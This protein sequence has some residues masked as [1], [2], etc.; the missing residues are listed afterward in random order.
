[1]ADNLKTVSINS[2]YNGF[3]E[4]TKQLSDIVAESGVKSVN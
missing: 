4:I 1:M 2:E 3:H